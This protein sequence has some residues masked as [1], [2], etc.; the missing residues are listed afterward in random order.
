LK[1]VISRKV[2]DKDRTDE[3][4]RKINV[5]SYWMTLRNIEDTGD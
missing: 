3:K 2:E 5:S 1:H 4:T